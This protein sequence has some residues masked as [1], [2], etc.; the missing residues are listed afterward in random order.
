MGIGVSGPTWLTKSASSLENRQVQK[1]WSR[2]VAVVVLGGRCE[3]EGAC[4]DCLRATRT[5]GRT[6]AK[7]VTNTRAHNP[8]ATSRDIENG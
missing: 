8:A 3:R 5:G 6:C 1:E 2:I 7:T 4:A